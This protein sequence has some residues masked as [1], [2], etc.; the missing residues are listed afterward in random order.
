MKIIF[1]QPKLFFGKRLKKKLTKKMKRTKDAEQRENKKR[2]K[3]IKSRWFVINFLCNVSESYLKNASNMI[4]LDEKIDLIKIYENMLIVHS[5]TDKWLSAFATKYSFE[6]TQ[7]TLTTMKLANKIKLPCIETLEKKE[8]KFKRDEIHRYYLVKINTSIDQLKIHAEKLYVQDNIRYVDIY[9]NLLVVALRKPIALST[10]RKMTEFNNNIHIVFC[11]QKSLKTIEAKNAIMKFE[12]INNNEN[13][14]EQKENHVVLFQTGTYYNRP[15]V[16][17]VLRNI[18]NSMSHG[19]KIRGHFFDM[20][21]A[22]QKLLDAFENMKPKYSCNCDRPNCLEIL[23][24]YGE[25]GISPDRSNNALGYVDDN[26]ILRLVI[27]PHNTT[28][29]YTSEPRL[30]ANPCKWYSYLARHMRKNVLERVN[31]LQ[32]KKYKTDLDKQQITRFENEI[33]NNPLEDFKKVLLAKKASQLG[34]C[35]KCNDKL[36]FGDEEGFLRLCNKENQVSP[37]RIDNN[38]IFYDDGNFRLVCVKCN[39]PENR[40]GRM[41]VETKAKN[42]PILFTP[43]LL[44]ECIDWLQR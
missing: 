7:I 35:L 31:Q 1:E 18:L 36:Y 41:D 14:L 21:L 11:S 15:V 13:I 5:Q 10:L 33:N 20:N 2:K 4:L 26:Q 17:H 25:Y 16:N 8:K 9:D 6:N 28:I 3:E 38:N 19:S 34:H 24:L 29:T 30:R 27:K 44:K 12:K 22:K 40:S 42:K 39:F 32:K 37:D 23:Q 43:D